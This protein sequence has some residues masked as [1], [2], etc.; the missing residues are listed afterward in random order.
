VR[1]V[2]EAQ[3]WRDRQCNGSAAKIAFSGRPRGRGEAVIDLPS[4]RD[5]DGRLYEFGFD[6]TP[7]AGVSVVVEQTVL[8]ESRQDLVVAASAKAMNEEPIL[9]I[10]E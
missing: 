8:D 1:N 7:I 4:C 6:D 9:S 2:T 10:A 3:S 5:A